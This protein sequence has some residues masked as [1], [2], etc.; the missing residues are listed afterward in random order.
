MSTETKSKPKKYYLL[1]VVMIIVS[2]LAIPFIS[3]LLESQ[4]QNPDIII[5]NIVGAPPL[6]GSSREYSL[7]VFNDGEKT[8]DECRIIFKDGTGLNEYKSSDYSFSLEPKGKE[9]V[10]ITTG[11]YDASGILEVQISCENHVSKLYSR[12]IIPKDPWA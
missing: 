1:T 3:D 5:K 4:F 11:K 7:E 10:N 2:I 9:I 12:T 6:L 8:A